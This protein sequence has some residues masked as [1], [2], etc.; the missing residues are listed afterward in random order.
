MK[1]AMMTNNYKPFVAGVPISIERLS[2]GLRALGHQV[3]IFAPSYDGQEEEEDIVRYHSLLRGVVGGFSVPD[4]LDPKIEKQFRKGQFDVIHVHHPML[5]GNTARYLSKKY[6]IPLVFTYH[7]RY[8]QYL[9][10]IGLSGVKEVIPAYIRKCTRACDV[11]IAPT[12]EIKEYLEEIKINASIRVLPTGLPRDSFCPDEEKAEGIRKEL[13]GEGKY[14]FC[15]V[16]RLAK[17]KNLEFILESLALFK[18]KSGMKKQ[19]DFKFALIGEGPE[20]TKL[21]QRVRELGLD[22]EVCF[23]GE[24]PNA[25]IKNYCAASDLFLFASKSETQGIV[26][27]ESMAAGTPVLAVKASGTQDIVKDGINGYMV[28]EVHEFTD[29]LMD[30]LEKKE[31]DILT[32]G[33]RQTAEQYDSYRIAGQAAEIYD[34]A[35]G[36]NKR[37]DSQRYGSTKIGMAGGGQIAVC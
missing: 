10:Y 19:A 7:T 37:R 13:I 36:I 18:D 9:H 20:R 22:K 4:S 17:E 14:L 27:L 15:T 34:R 29:K 32:Q 5:I 24:V 8:E 35:R 26:L 11:V 30:I 3:V 28:N 25:E 21:Q 2:E 23:V 1:I 31:L 12:P 16:A 33:A 6:G